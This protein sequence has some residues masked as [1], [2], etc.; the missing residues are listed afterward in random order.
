[1]PTTH[2]AFDLGAASGRALLGRLDGSRLQVEELARFR[3][4]PLTLGGRQHWNLH[5]LYEELL[6]CLRR[7]AAEGILPDS[8]GVD[9]WGVDFG[10]LAEDGSLLGLPVTYRDPRTSG[11]MESFFRMVPRERVYELTGI[12]FLPFNTLFQLEAMVRAGSPLLRIASDLLFMPDLFHHLLTGVRRTEFTFATTSQ[13]FNPTTGAWEGELLEALGLAPTLLQEVVPPATVLGPLQ[14]EVV[15]ATG[16][17][18]VPVVAVATHDTGAAVAAVPA[19]GEDWAYLSSGTWSLLGVEARQPALGPEALA[20]NI[21]SEGGVA[22]TFRVLRN[23]S[24]LWLLQECR[25]CWAATTPDTAGALEYAELIRIAEQAP[26]FL[27]LVDPDDPSFLNP[28]DMPTAIAAYCRRTGQP[29]PQ[30]PG[31]LTRCILESLALKYRYVLDL[32]RPLHPRA[33]TR[34]HV[35]GG[36]ARN[37]LLCQLTSEATALPVLAGPVEATAIG[38]LL[39]QALALGKLSSHRDLR[40]VVRESFPLERHEPQDP[41]RWREPYERFCQLQP[42]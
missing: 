31:P 38:N 3:N 37:R 19:E 20:A 21:T 6:A 25:R 9:T 8:L 28:P 23:I 4:D 40:H 18:P 10:L 30:G 29:A 16:T 7:C 32:L 12:Q 24:G 42:R 14:A 27:A 1:M 34:L 33:I 41:D 26:P 11:A 5:R 17:G 15:T 22:G 35:I 13:L 39:L 2:L 36:G